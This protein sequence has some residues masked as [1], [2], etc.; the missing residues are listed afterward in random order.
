LRAST[1]GPQRPLSMPGQARQRL[2]TQPWP[3]N[4]PAA[5]RPSDCLMAAQGQTVKDIT[6]LIQVGEDYV[7]DVIH[8]FNERGFDALDPKWSGGRPKTISDQVLVFLPT[9]G[10]WIEAEF[11]AIAAY[12]RRRFARAEPKTTFAPNSPTR[13]WTDYPAKAA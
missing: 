10:S 11:A 6:K 7:R 12:V 13:S 4:R 9:H 5:R 8:A 3:G 2:V 1:S